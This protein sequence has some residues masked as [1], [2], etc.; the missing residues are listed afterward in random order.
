MTKNQMQMRTCKQEQA[1]L[2]NKKK[3]Q[4]LFNIHIYI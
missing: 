4:K 3:K 2:K 1:E